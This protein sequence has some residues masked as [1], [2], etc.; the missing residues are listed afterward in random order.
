MRAKLLAPLFLLL[1]LCGAVAASFGP[2]VRSRAETRAAS[3]GARVNIARVRPFWLGVQL[4][5]VDV[6]LAD[7]PS[8]RVHVDSVQVHLLFSGA[9]REVLVRGGELSITGELGVLKEQFRALS[10]RLSSSKGSGGGGGAAIAAE[11]LRAVWASGSE[12]AKASGISVSRGPDG[13]KVGASE[14][15]LSHEGQSLEVRNSSVEFQRAADSFR[16]LRLQAGELSLGAS[17]KEENAAGGA[18]EPRAPLP[19]RAAR[20][21][22][23]VHQAAQAAALLLGEGASVDVGRLKLSLQRGAETLHIG[24]G[25]LSLKPGQGSLLVSLAPVETSGGGAPLLFSAEIPTDPAQELALRVSGGPVT[26]AMLGVHEK[27]LGLLD[28]AKTTLEAGGRVRLSGAADHVEVDLRGGIKGLALEQPKLSTEPVRGIDLQFTMVGGF[29]L[30]GSRVRV[31]RGELD[32]GKVHSEASGLFVKEGTHSNLQ[33]KFAVPLASCQAMLDAMPAGLAPSLVG[34]RMGGT[35]TLNGRIGFDSKRPNDT[36]VEFQFLNECRVTHAPPEVHVSR[37]R[38][39]FR[40]K[41]YTPENKQIEVESG[42]GTPGWVSLAG[43]TPYMEASVL[44]TEDGGFRR[45]RGFDLEAIRNSIRENLKAGRFVRGA[46]TISMQTA[47]NLYL[48]RDKTLGRKLQETI[49]TMYL[50]Q[51]LSKEQILELYLNCIEYGPMIYGI[52]PA[53]QHYFHTTAAELSLGQALY[54]SSILP[55]PKR[56]H[57]GPDGKVTAPFMGY[58][59]KLMRGMAKRHLIREDELEEGLAEPVVFGQPRQKTLSKTDD[60]GDDKPPPDAAQ[61]RELF[62]PF[63]PQPVEKL[64][65]LRRAPRCLDAPDDLHL[66]VLPRVFQ[67]HEEAADGAG[68]GVAGAVDQA[69]D[70]CVQDGSGAHEARFE[71]ADERAPGEPPALQP[72]GCG[73]Q[74]QELRVGRGIAVDLASVV[75]RGQQLSCGRDHEGPDRDIPQRRRA[76]ADLDGVAHPSFQVG[77]AGPVGAVGHGL[78]GRRSG[79]RRSILRAAASSSL[80]VEAARTSVTALA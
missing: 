31:D 2:I 50:E 77:R 39:P 45:H 9:T 22:G 35:F 48:T 63:R 3:L 41:V 43:I 79:Q 32:V 46:S 68:L 72:P 49:L 73:A 51:E 25:A 19:E 62:L 65:E 20:W 26:L 24:P 29:A 37:F 10:A 15:S 23:K 66:V 42:P 47:K 5:G 36:Q 54:L 38:Q 56:Q 33:G 13:W 71:G 69:L 1:A 60:D 21:K 11:G 7:L 53:S 52:G 70:P 6:S 75:A 57:F 4:E 59:H 27:D 74:G 61:G 64:L 55:N 14:A 76:G 12:G 80:A 16:L 30:D 34:M 18:Q 58:L 67:G 44:T 40:R 28:V 17:I 78:E 8:A